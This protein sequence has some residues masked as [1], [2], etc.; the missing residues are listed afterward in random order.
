MNEHLKRNWSN[1]FQI[2]V[3]ALIFFGVFFLY[4]KH[5]VGN[6]SSIS[7]WFI[8]YEGGFVHELLFFNYFIL[9]KFTT[10]QTNHFSYFFSNF[11]FVSSSRD[12]GI[13]T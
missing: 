6:D 2:Y 9:Q 10:K 4:S 7:D 1:Y 8:N 3:F 5:D 12:R 13:R 11:Y